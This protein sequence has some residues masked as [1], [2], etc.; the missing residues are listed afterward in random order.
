MDRRVARESGQGGALMSFKDLAIP[1]AALNVPVIRL[2]HKSKIPMDKAWQT[3]ATTDVDKILAW[4]A[5]TPNANCACVAQN[6]GVLFFE[7]DEDGVIA[8]YEQ[9]TGEIFPETFAVESRPGRYHF[10][11]SQTDESRKCGSITQKEI[12]FGSLRQNNAYVVSPGSIHP[13]TGQPYTILNDS[14]IVP[15]PTRLIE[16]LVAQKTKIE[17]ASPLAASQSPIPHGQHDVTLTAIAGKLREDG[18]EYEEILPILI[19]TCE[20]RCVN[21]GSD[22]REMC[23]KIAKSVCR[24]P[25]GTPGPTVLIEGKLPGQNV[26]SKQA[27]AP[28]PAVE[29]WSAVEPLNDQLSSVAPFKPEFLPDSIRPWVVDVS[30]RMSVPMDFTG[31]CALATISGVL[32]QRVFVYPKAKDKE[33]KESLAL[34]GAVVASSGKTKTPTW[35]TFTN[36]VVEK[37]SDWRQ[38]HKA[39]ALKYAQDMDAWVRLS[40]EN[41]LIEKKTG[42]AQNTPPQPT[43]PRESCRRLMLNDATPEKMHDVMKNSPE[44][45]FYYRDELSSWVAELDKEGR[46]VQR[47]LF[48]AAMNGDDPY[49][50]DRIGRE[51]GFAI[52]CASVFGGFQPELLREFLNNTRN[53]DDGTIPRFALITW[54]DDVD[55][56]TIDRPSNDIAK[57]LFRRVIRD[58]AEMKEKQVSMHFSPEAQIIFD[59]WFVELNRKVSNETHSGKRSHLS[60]YKGGLPKIAALLQ[61]V[62]LVGN[63]Q[64]AGNHQIDAAH[65]NK[66]LAL[67]VY[68]EKHMH[69]IYDCIQNPIQKAVSAIAKHIKDGS[70][71]D[72]FTARYVHRRCWKDL[73]KAEHIDLALETLAEMGWVREIPAPPN[74]RGGRPTVQWELNPALGKE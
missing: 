25:A 65:L 21:Y 18:L 8:R 22:Y 66:A 24:Y 10:Y 23:T 60:K 64:L 11:F 74:P 37:E 1:M 48:L 34:S 6:D 72:S 5:E 69:R 40:E 26:V 31:I 28:A 44:G 33:W 9:E 17:K 62:D 53:V 20:Q 14:P 7:T 51:G 36:I 43:E 54:P 67:L 39:L 57:Q 47:G 3:L 42:V 68:L 2:Q 61:I 29:E 59:Q 50:I 45:L 41:E 55:L 27:V 35:K 52:M 32:G 46:E 49:S 30:E 70:L 16:W 4:H 71:K 73:S 63:G 19:R 56:P 12:P 13:T 15:I 58:L 38:E